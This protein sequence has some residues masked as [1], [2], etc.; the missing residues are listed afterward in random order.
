MS[1]CCSLVDFWL[2]QK[3][4]ENDLGQSHH[5]YSQ[6]RRGRSTTETLSRWRGGRPWPLASAQR[7]VDSAQRQIPVLGTDWTQMLHRRLALV[8]SPRARVL[9][10][11]TSSYPICALPCLSSTL[12]WFRECPSDVL[13]FRDVL[14][15]F[16]GHPQYVRIFAE[17]SVLLGWPLV[18]DVGSA[19][20][21]PHR[22]GGCL[23]PLDRVSTGATGISHD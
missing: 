17:L 9:A 11:H 16:V 14:W 12:T 15:T 22:L 10:E 5:C 4:L 8:Q 20:L 1:F 7:S 18:G 6:R 21:R 23:K 3:V 13:T 19:A 2:L